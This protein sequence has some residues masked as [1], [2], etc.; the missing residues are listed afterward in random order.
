MALAKLA[1]VRNT[2]SINQLL[3]H[4]EE[5]TNEKRWRNTSLAYG[6]GVTKLLGTSPF[7]AQGKVMHNTKREKKDWY[8]ALLWPYGMRVS[9]AR[10]LPQE[11]WAG[12]GTAFYVAGGSCPHPALTCNI[13]FNSREDKTKLHP[14]FTIVL[15]ILLIK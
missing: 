14:A 15:T 7:G 2:L 11:I 8:E 1:T 3:K 12:S 9:F 5:K 6:S 10:H 4:R 13:E